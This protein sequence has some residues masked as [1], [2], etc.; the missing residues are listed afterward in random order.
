MS[1][2]W[3]RQSVCW[4]Q[5]TA[6]AQA[7]SSLTRIRRTAVRFWRQATCICHPLEQFFN[8]R[9]SRNRLRA[10]G[11]RS[12]G[13]VP[14]KFGMHPVQTNRVPL[15]AQLLDQPRVH[16]HGLLQLLDC[17][18]LADRVGLVDAAGAEHQRVHIVLI[19]LGFGAVWDGDR[20]LRAGRAGS[21]RWSGKI[22]RMG[23]CGIRMGVGWCVGGEWTG[24]SLPP[25]PQSV[26]RT[27]GPTIQVRQRLIRRFRSV[28]L[29]RRYPRNICARPFRLSAFDQFANLGVTHETAVRAAFQTLLQHC[30]RQAGWTLVPEHAVNPRRGR[31][32]VDDGANRGPWRL[33]DSGKGSI[34]GSA[35]KLR[36]SELGFNRRRPG[37]TDSFSA[38]NIDDTKSRFHPPP[39]T[40]P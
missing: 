26:A 11:P 24:L 18:P 35:G 12:Q 16:L 33:G 30:A 21:R 29:D 25:H 20:A 39:A 15:P 14:Q 19:A 22:R 17:D 5:L 4:R 38:V 23:I 2:L 40:R 37:N 1:E 27:L 6:A 13:H 9:G 3:F 8:R 36:K 7:A 31:R 28:S 34:L 10:R 32:I